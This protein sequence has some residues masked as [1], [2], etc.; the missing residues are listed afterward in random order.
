MCVGRGFVNEK[1]FRYCIDSMAQIMY[2]VCCT[3]RMVDF[4][5][6]FRASRGIS[7]TLYPQSAKVGVMFAFGTKSLWFGL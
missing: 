2:T 4:V 7:G 6:Y 3:I 5:L 1:S